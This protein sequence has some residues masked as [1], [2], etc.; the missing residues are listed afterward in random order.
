MVFKGGRGGSVIT[1]GGMKSDAALGD[2]MVFKKRQRGKS[3]I[4]GGRG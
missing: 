1:K 2:H 4:T 3:V